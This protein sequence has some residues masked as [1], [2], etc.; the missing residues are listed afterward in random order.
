MNAMKDPQYNFTNNWFEANAKEIWDLLLPQINPSRILEIGSY[1]GASG[2]YLID[3]LAAEREIEL[4]CIDTWEGGLEHKPGGNAQTN[5]QTVEALFHQNIQKSVNSSPNKVDLFIHKGFSDVELI[6]LLAEGKANYFDF[7]YIDG[8]HQAADVLADAVL[9][10]KL[11]R[12]NGVIAFDDYLWQ[13]DLPYGTDPVRCPKFAIDAFTN[14]YC[15][16]LRLIRAPLYQMY[17]EKISD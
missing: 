4:H 17:V 14:I 12:K 11:L 5:M 6:K 3:T 16:K 15:R 8:S 1:E 13:E 2:C 7:I 9:G 10:F